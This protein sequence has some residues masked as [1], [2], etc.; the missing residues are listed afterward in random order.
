MLSQALILYKNNIQLFTRGF[1]LSRSTALI[2]YK[3]NIQQ[4]NIVDKFELPQGIG[5]NP[6]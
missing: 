6:L 2:L 3:N 1:N 4:D 5:V